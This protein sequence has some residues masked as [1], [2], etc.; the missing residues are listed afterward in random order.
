[1]WSAWIDDNK[2]VSQLT[3]FATIHY[4]SFTHSKCFIFQKMFINKVIKYR[5]K[6]DEFLIV[7][8]LYTF[9]SVRKVSKETVA[10]EK[11]YNGFN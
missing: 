5:N 1:M 7:V 3:P 9:L 10:G 8:I 11:F 6:K 2:S 4:S